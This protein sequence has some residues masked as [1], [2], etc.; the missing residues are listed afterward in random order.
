[1]PDAIDVSG[2]YKLFGETAAISNISFK[3]SKGEFFCV[4]GPNASGKTTLLNLT[5]GAIPPDKGTIKTNGKIGYCHQTPMLFSDLTVSQ[6]LEI[7]S[8]LSLAEKKE[9]KK[10]IELLGLSSESNKKACDLS[11]GTKKKLELA[12]SLL[13]NPDILLFDE[14]TAG[15]DKD[16][17]DDFIAFLKKIKGKKTIVVATHQLSDFKK[18][19]DRQLILKKEKKE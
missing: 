5:A 9:A 6:N 3:V 19:C 4:C 17:L 14:P 10:T 13:S 11:S 18:L 12:V 2:V 15:L 16:S 7:F 1:M 8:M